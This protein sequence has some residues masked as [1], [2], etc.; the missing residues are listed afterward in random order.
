MYID[1]IRV[2]VTAYRGTSSP[3][4][5]GKGDDIPESPTSCGTITIS[6]T[7]YYDGT[8]FQNGGETYLATSPLVYEPPK[9]SE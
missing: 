2:R 4:S 8:A 9:N 3:Y 7:Q 1:Q 5:I 6:G